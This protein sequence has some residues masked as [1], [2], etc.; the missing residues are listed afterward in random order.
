MA[1][2]TKITEKYVSEHPS[3]KDC[4]KTGLINYSSLT[5]QITKDLNIDLK[6]N[7]DAILIACRR[8]YRK[9][10]SE[11]TNEKKILEILKQSKVEIKN[12]IIAVVVEKNIFLDNLLALEKEIK[13]KDDVFHIIEGANAIT[14]VTS[15]DFLA[16]IRRLFKTKII[17][18]N[19][20]LVEITLK[21]PKEIETTAGVVP[22]AYSLFGEHGINIV[23]TMSCWTDT[24][25]VI[26]EK[27]I[28][29]AMEILRF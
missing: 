12:K 29:N 4:L 16:E 15:E 11:E 26:D 20:N 23:E 6:K 1:N 27:D 9:V 21:S 18:E 19:T 8:Y 2:I 25:F 10:R 7:F 24:L 28:A 13:K 3:I 22:Y 5:R 14:I 17:K